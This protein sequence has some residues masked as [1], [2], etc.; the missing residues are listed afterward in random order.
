MP[1]DDEAAIPARTEAGGQSGRTPESQK[2]GK[3]E[4]QNGGGAMVGLNFKVRAGFRKEFRLFC[5]EHDLSLVDALAQAFE[6]LKRSKG[7]K[8]AP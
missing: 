2:S 7:G 1:V 3:A 6:L 4:K 5:A 8:A